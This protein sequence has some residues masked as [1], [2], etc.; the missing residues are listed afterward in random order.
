MRR[1]E[2]E[3]LPQRHAEQSC[4]Q[5]VHGRIDGSERE[6]RAGQFG[7][8]Q[9]PHGERVIWTQFGQ[10]WSNPTKVTVQLFQ[11]GVV[12]V[13]HERRRLAEPGHAV[14]FHF[15]DQRVLNRDC[16]PG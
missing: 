9:F 10:Q 7:G 3:G 15:D 14:L 8:E 6:G 4:S 12:V 16:L 5:I 13:G 1:V 2:S 11:A